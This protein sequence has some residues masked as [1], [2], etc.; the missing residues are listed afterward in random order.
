MSFLIG[1]HL[2]NPAKKI[3]WDPKNVSNPHLMIVGKSGSGK[4]TLLRKVIEYLDNENYITFVIDFHGDI[5]TSKEQEFEFTTLNPK[6]G[7]G[8]FEFEKDPIKGGIYN[9][10]EELLQIFKSVYFENFS[11]LREAVIKRLLLDVYYVK[12][13]DPDNPKSWDKEI[14]KLPTLL[15]LKKLI[16]LIKNEIKNFEENREVYSKNIEKMNLIYKKVAQKMVETEEE[17]QKILAQSEEHFSKFLEE[18]TI[19]FNE[20]EKK[21]DSIKAITKKLGI[22]DFGFYLQRNVLKS[23]ESIEVYIDAMIESKVFSQHNPVLKRGKKTFRFN[24]SNLSDRVMFFMANLIIQ[25]IFNKSRKSFNPEDNRPVAL[26]TF[27]VID[28]SKLIMP[29]GKEKENPFNFLNRIVSESRK[30]GL[31]VILVSQRISHYS[32]E[33]LSNIATK[34]VLKLS[35]NDKKV[36]KSKIGIKDKKDWEALNSRPGVA[37]VML[38]EKREIVLL[39]G[40]ER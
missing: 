9:R 13:F 23:I 3:F 17:F 10:V 11:P 36:V 40:F 15:D 33:M 14:D 16:K 22:K 37:I 21:F 1:E 19:L 24:L 6:Y 26:K 5:K 25:R 39:D 29:Q 18:I 34:V 35:E 8:V 2:Y 38:D 7:I 31:G 32:E 12:G 4:T 27:I 20:K 30:F 28:E